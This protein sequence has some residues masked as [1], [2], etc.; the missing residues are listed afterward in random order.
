MM[1]NSHAAFPG[2]RSEAAATARSPG[3]RPN[4]QRLYL[5]AIVLIWLVITHDMAR[6]EGSKSFCR[7]DLDEEVLVQLKTRIPEGFASD[8]DDVWDLVRKL[9]YPLEIPLSFIQDQADEPLA[10]PIEEQTLE[11]ILRAIGDQYERYRCEVYSGRLVLRSSDEIFDVMISEVDI[12]K[13]Y[14]IPARH[15]YIEHLRASDQ[16]FKDW[17]DPIWTLGGGIP[18]M[19]ADRLTLSPRAPVILHLVQL[20]GKNPTVYFKVPAPGGSLWRTI[21]FGAVR[22]PW[23]KILPTAPPLTEDQTGDEQ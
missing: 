7:G 6:A 21:I 16:R 8:V 10:L 23:G 1:S 12:V 17:Q 22:R 2:S 5:I 18:A 3:F 13:E 11:D 20:L 9:H 15:A 19:F 14:R 4:N